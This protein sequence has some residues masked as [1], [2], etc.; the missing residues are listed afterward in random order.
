VDA[1]A[2]SGFTAAASA[3]TA[4]IATINLLL[5][6]FIAFSSCPIFFSLLIYSLVK[7][8][9]WFLFSIIA[10]KG[11]V[12]KGFNFFLSFRSFIHSTSVLWLSQ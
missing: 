3:I 6:F 5:K 12:G 11:G 2:I 8:G 9:K 7:S 4:I 1:L 10:E